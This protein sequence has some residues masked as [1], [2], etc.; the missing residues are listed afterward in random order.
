M[1]DDDIYILQQDILHIEKTIHIQDFFI[2]SFTEFIQNPKNFI[3]DFLI[4]SDE[5]KNG[6][7]MPS[8]KYFD[9]TEASV[10]K[11]IAQWYFLQKK[12]ETI[13]ESFLLNAD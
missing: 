6:N 8:A 10:S 12:S 2:L 7:S 5:L 1:C 4:G 13:L 3:K 11:G 9:T